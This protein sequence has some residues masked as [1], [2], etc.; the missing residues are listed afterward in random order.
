MTVIGKPNCSLCDSAEAQ[1]S[2]VV[3]EWQPS[4]PDHPVE[5]ST[6]NMYDDPDLISRY[7]EEVPVVQING[8]THTYWKVDADRL[9][10][11]L[12]QAAEA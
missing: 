1:V 11:A 10:A 3:R 5:V 2:A 4:H 8:S 12:N 6:V 7:S 9:S